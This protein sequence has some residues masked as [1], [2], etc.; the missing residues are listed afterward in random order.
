MDRAGD[1]TDEPVLL[2]VVDHNILPSLDP[3]HLHPFSVCWRKGG[4]RPALPTPTPC[5]PSFLARQHDSPPF[6]RTGTQVRRGTQVLHF[7]H[8]PYL[9]DHAQSD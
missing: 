6:L 9:P 3:C 1:Q 2:H 8:I 5:I 7:L 4:R